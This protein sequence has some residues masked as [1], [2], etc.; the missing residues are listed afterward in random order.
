MRS[1]S[2]RCSARDGAQ[3]ERE[4]HAAGDD[5]DQ[6]RLHLDLADRADDAAAELV[7]EA[8][9]LDDRL[10]RRD[11]GVEAEVHR[12]R[13][14]VVG[15]AAEVQIAV[16]VAD[17]RL[18]DP[19]S[20]AGV[21][22]DA[23]L[24]DV[25]LD[26]AGQVVERVDRLA[27][28]RGLVAGR[29]GGVPERDAV[30]VADR[31]AQLLLA[32]AL[33]HDPRAEQH[34]P[35]ARALL[36]EERDQPQ[37]EVVAR[38]GGQAADLERRADAERAVVLA[39]VAVRVAVRADA[40][41]GRV[42]RDVGRDQRADRVLPDAEKPIALELAREVGERVAVDG[43]VGVAADRAVAERVVGAREGLDVALDAARERSRSMRSPTSPS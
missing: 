21:L 31:L 25:H 3:V 16:D 36:L 2:S 30:L 4:A 8:L 1:R 43:G 20:R 38:L 9:E 27:P 40:E 22:Q 33:Q 11:R 12:R 34:L 18:D 26:P 19:E 41:R 42:R 15:A 32:D 10:G 28:A 13:A 37:R 17:D 39:A 23:A 6:A 35:E 29:L 5:V 14:G 7:R 24:L